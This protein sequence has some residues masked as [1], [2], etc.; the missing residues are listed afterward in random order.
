MK[1][2]WRSL[3]KLLLALLPAG[4]PQAAA[5]TDHS[6]GTTA[7]G[8]YVTQRMLRVT[9]R[10][11][12]RYVNAD[13][14]GVDDRASAEA[15]VPPARHEVYGTVTL[16]SP[17]GFVVGTAHI[18]DQL[19]SVVPPR[20]TGSYGTAGDPT[21]PLVSF[22]RVCEPDDV[23][24]TFERDFNGAV[25][26]YRELAGERR[27]TFASAEEARN[28]SVDGFTTRIA[29]ADGNPIRRPPGTAFF[30]LADGAL[31][32]V[33]G[34]LAVTAHGYALTQPGTSSSATIYYESPGK[35]NENL[36]TDSRGVAMSAETKK[37]MS[38]GPVLD[39]DG[40]LVGI[41]RAVE[42][43]I[44]GATP[45]PNDAITYLFVPLIMLRDGGVLPPGKTV[46]A[47][48]IEDCFSFRRFNN[49]WTP[50]PPEPLAALEWI[51]LGASAKIVVDTDDC[52]LVARRDISDDALPAETISAGIRP[53]PDAPPGLWEAIANEKKWL[54]YTLHTGEFAYVPKPDPERRDGC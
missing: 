19:F 23:E 16:I 52:P 17:D 47:S 40:N 13:G 26:S 46:R 24:L 39:A 43:L 3:P 7:F 12:F 49:D 5:Q 48:N 8:D 31:E 21:D 38:G 15:A 51:D 22:V 50:S 27:P 45:G 33:E 18:F 1:P 42:S 53:E 20:L 30:C 28:P 37:G 36:G 29:S 41:N 32:D 6:A 35:V 2:V 4:I 44:A 54:R 34:G 14:T 11:K 10:C 25:V 9:A